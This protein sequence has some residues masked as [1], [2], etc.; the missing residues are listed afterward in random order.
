MRWAL[1]LQA[2]TKFAKE[3]RLQVLLVVKEHDDQS[4]LDSS[5]QA[6]EQ[7]TCICTNEVVR[8]NVGKLFPDIVDV[9]EQ[10]IA[11]LSVAD[12]NGIGIG[13]HRY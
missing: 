2:D 5:P 10:R 4:W 6:Q 13:L 1:D 8:H 11:F 9:L 12:Q 3:A 7:G